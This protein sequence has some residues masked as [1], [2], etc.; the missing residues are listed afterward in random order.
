VFSKNTEYFLTLS[1]QFTD[2]VSPPLV[3]LGTWQ[4]QPG[5]VR[6]AVKAAIDAGYRHIE[7]AILLH[8]VYVRH[9]LTSHLNSSTAL[10][11]GNE[12]EVG[13]GI[14]D[15]GIA[16]EEL[17]VTTKLD[18]PW[19]KRVEEGINSSLKSLGLDYVD[20]YLMVRPQY[21]WCHRC[22]YI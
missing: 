12:K 8:E 20:L 2:F 18:N 16:R 4:S 11:Y 7:W 15:S 9:T 17:W 3:G 22:G 1:D 21:T 13:E 14:K 5:E 6:S 19:H 10:A